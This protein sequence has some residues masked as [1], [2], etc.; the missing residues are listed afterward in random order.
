MNAPVILHD[1]KW[2]GMLSIWG[3]GDAHYQGVCYSGLS[4]RPEEF[5]HEIGKDAPPVT[6]SLLRYVDLECAQ[7]FLDFALK[8]LIPEEIIKHMK[9]TRIYAKTINMWPRKF[10][11]RV[12]KD[13]MIDEY[14][15]DDEEKKEAERAKRD[16]KSVYGGC[17]PWIRVD[18]DQCLPANVIFAVSVLL[19]Y[20][21][22][23]GPVLKMLEA[24][25]KSGSKVPP[26][27]QFC[28]ASVVGRAGGHALGPWSWAYLN[29]FAE[30]ALNYSWKA[31][32]KK[33]MKKFKPFYES[34][35][36]IGAV[37]NFFECD[38]GAWESGR[39]EVCCS[40]S[41]ATSTLV[42]NKDISIISRCNYARDLLDSLEKSL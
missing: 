17:I 25:Q 19:R 40:S 8:H 39:V 28:Y 32:F 38:W 1:H 2:A 41:G 16:R 36:K 13:E 15:F 4:H 29:N 33:L 7:L 26:D 5:I 3:Q 23:H 37:D 9:I 14:G 24:L 21:S 22:E 27:A 30:V 42:L 31:G 12:P 35:E 10:K 6:I 20:A 18:Y 34:P 11:N